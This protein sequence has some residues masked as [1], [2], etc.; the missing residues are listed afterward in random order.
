MYFH[1]RYKWVCFGCSVASVQF[2]LLLFPRKSVSVASIGLKLQACPV[3]HGDG[4]YIKQDKQSP[5]GMDIT[6]EPMRTYDVDDVTRYN[7]SS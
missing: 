4:S 6:K 5:V 7:W 3:V 2:R 1:I